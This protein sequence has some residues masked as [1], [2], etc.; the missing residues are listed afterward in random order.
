MSNERWVF[1][2]GS[3]LWQPG[4]VPVESVRARLAGWHRALC[5][6]SLHYRG[7]PHA[8]GLV[9]GLARGGSC[10][11][12]A[13]RVDP[14]AEASVFQALWDR[15]MISGVYRP[16]QTTVRLA[17]GRRPSALVFPADPHHAQY[18]GRLSAADQLALIRHGVGSAGT[19]YDYLAQTVSRL[20]ELGI[21]DRN[22]Q[23]ILRLCNKR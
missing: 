16:R 21:V 4:F 2:Y 10:V 23:N 20:N 8:P 7:Q 6:F 13:L 18:A 22:L 12:H 11:G 5:I 19:A 15:E 3:L 17:D 1:A 9:L 14:D